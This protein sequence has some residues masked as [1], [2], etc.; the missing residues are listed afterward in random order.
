MTVNIS[1]DPWV[2]LLLGQ[3]FGS[4]RLVGCIGIGG[5]GYVFEA[6]HL[7][8][9]GR[10]A[11]KILK[12]G[13]AGDDVVDFENEG[14]LLRA[15]AKCSGVINYIDGGTEQV[16]L[17]SLIGVT[18]PVDVRYHVLP[19]ASGSLDELVSD[20]LAR[21]DLGW[22]DRIGMW[23]DTVVALKQM[24]DLGI[25]H[26]DLKSSNCLLM[27][28]GSSAGVRLADLG[29]AKNLAQ[30]PSRSIADYVNGRGD[31]RFAPPE[32]LLFQGGYE[33]ADFIAADYYGVGSILVELITG[34]PMTASAMGDVR[35]VMGQAQADISMG[36]KRPLAS[37]SMQYRSAVDDVIENV[38]RI[39]RDDLRVVLEYL[40]NPEPFRRVTSGPFSKDRAA[41]HPLD[42]VI[43]RADI[44]IRRIEIQSREERRRMRLRTA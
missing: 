29:R 39:I 37:L 28:R 12:H 22:A 30:S 43:R 3:P 23:R 21:R 5:F 17:R 7:D 4:Y 13:V 25:V 32:Y 15:L 9:G 19:I 42:W 1:S 14:R 18:V 33:A 34:F 44:M 6:E 10:V 16:Q 36:R 24:H 20:A 27:V 31:L 8:S 41:R 26:R 2:A 40:C 11:I 35:A 38:P